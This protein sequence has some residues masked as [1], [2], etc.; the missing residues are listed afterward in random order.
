MSI[1]TITTN[2]F[3]QQNIKK[4]HRPYFDFIKG[5]AILMVVAIHT[6]ISC[7]LD[8]IGGITSTIFRQCLNCAV[9][10]F[11][12]CSA[13]FL[14]STNLSSFSQCWQFW[15]KQIPKVYIPTILW[16]IPTFTIALYSGNN[17]IK[18]TIL[19]LICGYSIYY[20]IALII[21]YYLLLPILKKYRKTALFISIPITII[22]LLYFTKISIA[23]PL[24]LI[25]GAAP[26][27]MW[28]LYFMLGITLAFSKRTYSL[29]FPIILIILGIIIQFV[30]VL[31][32]ENFYNS[33][34][35][36]IKA[37]SVL[38]SSSII[39]LLFSKKLEDIY[40]TNY[41]TRIIE[42][43]G[44]TSFI[45][46]LCHCYFINIAHH[47]FH[48]NYWVINFSLSLTLTIIFLLIFSKLTPKSIHKY[49]GL[50]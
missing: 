17:P 42:Y 16:S 50:K 45:I 48:S 43:F 20:F 31:Y 35:L 34:R 7:N 46:Y 15:K 8:S 18:Q 9:P 41:Y 5:I 39:F 24:P 14:S 38:Y 37:S 44:Q 13:Y 36:G 26:F 22:S 32:L 1:N 3:L 28:F 2:S 49:I 11:L 19:L 25:I 29:I 21:Q 23:N 6:T 12:A 33:F 10:I 30:E 40:T 4:K 27:N 47:I